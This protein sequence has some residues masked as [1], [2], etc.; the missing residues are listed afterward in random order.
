MS[1]IGSLFLIL[2]H[3]STI[4]NMLCMKPC[5]AECW[6]QVVVVKIVCTLIDLHQVGHHIEFNTEDYSLDTV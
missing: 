3:T 4:Q 6:T 1:Q 5:E 2:A